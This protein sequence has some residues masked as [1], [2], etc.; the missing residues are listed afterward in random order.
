VHID[1]YVEDQWLSTALF[2]A[3]QLLESWSGN[4][5]GEKLQVIVSSDEF[6]A[7]VKAHMLRKGESWISDDIDG[8]RG[9]ILTATSDESD[10]WAL[11]IVIGDRP[12]E[13]SP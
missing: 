9:P 10:L 3:A 11:G 7:V 5:Q 6:G 12:S 1:D 8:Y 2:F 13:G 4:S